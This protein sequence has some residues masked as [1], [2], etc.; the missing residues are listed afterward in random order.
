MKD[1]SGYLAM[2]TLEEVFESMRHGLGDDLAPH[3]RNPAIV[4][5]AVGKVREY[6]RA[7]D[8]VAEARPELCMKKGGLV[9]LWKKE[10]TSQDQPEQI[11]RAFAYL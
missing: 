2:T 8:K 10:F 3:M 4:N 5:I 6:G 7:W 1:I 11:R 9:A